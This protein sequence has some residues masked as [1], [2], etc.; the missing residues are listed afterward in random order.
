[1][2]SLLQ[3]AE[4]EKITAS[5]LQQQDG[6]CSAHDSGVPVS[7]TDIYNVHLHGA[8]HGKNQALIVFGNQICFSAQ[9]L[10]S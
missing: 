3:Q 9:V 5:P 6:V 10:Y 2:D 7:Y 1:M 4:P 8:P